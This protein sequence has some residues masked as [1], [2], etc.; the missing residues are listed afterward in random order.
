[1]PW[2]MWDGSLWKS[3]HDLDER[4]LVLRNLCLLNSAGPRW[5]RVRHQANPESGPREADWVY[6]GSVG[7]I[8]PLCMPSRW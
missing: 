5:A 7:F 8:M 6:V 1:M 2:A 3:R 4:N